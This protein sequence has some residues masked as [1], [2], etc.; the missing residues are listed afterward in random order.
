MFQAMDPL[1]AADPTESFCDQHTDAGKCSC[2]PDR[3]LVKMGFLQDMSEGTGYR[4]RRCDKCWWFWAYG[5]G[6]GEVF[7]WDADHKSRVPHSVLT[8]WILD[9]SIPFGEQYF[10][11]TKLSA[12]YRQPSYYR[13]PH[14]LGNKLT[15]GTR[16][17]TLLPCEAFVTPWPFGFLQ[18]PYLAPV[19]SQ[20]DAPVLTTRGRLFYRYDGLT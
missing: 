9:R 17:I 18:C 3:S 7:L 4:C 2:G 20:D 8:T 12:D 16:R 14:I 19:P 6:A 15:D 13:P 1:R 10:K 11:P 5:P